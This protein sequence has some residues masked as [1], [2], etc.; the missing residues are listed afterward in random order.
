MLNDQESD[1][2]QDKGNDGRNISTL[3]GNRG[4]SSNETMM[5]RCIK[6]FFTLINVFCRKL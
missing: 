6:A 5:Y 2:W 1:G 4:R 3:E